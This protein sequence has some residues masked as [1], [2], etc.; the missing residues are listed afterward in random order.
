MSFQELLGHPL[1]FFPA[2]I[3][4]VFKVSNASSNAPIYGPFETLG[5]FVILKT[6]CMGAFVTFSPFSSP[7]S[8]SQKKTCLKK[9]WIE[10]KKTFWKGAGFLPTK[11]KSGNMLD[12]D[13]EKTC[14][15]KC[16]IQTE[17]LFGKVLDSDRNES[18][19]RVEFENFV[20][21][22]RRMLGLVDHNKD[23]EGF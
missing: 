23:C 16:W 5:V 4:S 18:V 15:K 9:C 1:A 20:N 13:R 22:L 7:F 14:L 17:K 21:F 11:K 3:Q 19:T 12:S 10:T 6:D 8:R 2:P